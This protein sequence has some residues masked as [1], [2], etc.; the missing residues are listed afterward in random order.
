MKIL[1]IAPQKPRLNGIV[2][3]AENFRNIFNEK[4][5]YRIKP[6]IYEKD[7]SRCN[8]NICQAYNAFIIAKGIKEKSKN[9]GITNIHAEIGCT[10]YAEYY[11]TLFL[12]LLNVK[13]PISITVHDPPTLISKP[14]QHFPNILKGYPKKIFSKIAELFI[15]KLAN[16]IVLIN[17]KNIFTLT[18]RGMFIFEN[19]YEFCKNKINNIPIFTLNT[20]VSK[21]INII[22]SL[23]FWSPRRGV[24]NIVK[25]LTVLRDKNI[26]I[27]DGWEV[28]IGGGILDDVISTDYFENISKS[29]IESKLDNVINVT[30][31]LPDNI[32]NK[33]LAQA[34]IY[35]ASDLQLKNRGIPASANLIRAIGSGCALIVTDAS[36]ID[37]YVKDNINGYVYEQTDYLKLAN[38]LMMLIKD[39]NI[40]R[41]MQEKNRRL[42]KEFYDGKHSISKFI[43]Q[44]KIGI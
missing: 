2:D 30:K 7:I 8:E 19:K 18:E 37:E 16:I 26:A 31:Y 24:E 20:K 40:R 28:V 21:K 35:I 3:Y 41:R 14:I 29:V 44:I 12:I 4:S 13:V 23:G 22:L 5:K 11:I 43:N 27:I 42:Y 9:G 38:F 10:C 34:S 1:H 36:G 32:Y 6:L 17:V 25:A 15:V 33:Y 39:R